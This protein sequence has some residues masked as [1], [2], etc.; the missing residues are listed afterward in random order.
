[1]AP[2]TVAADAAPSTA[3]VVAAPSTAAD[4]AA[5]TT[6]PAADRQLSPSRSGSPSSSPTC[7]GQRMVALRPMITISLA[8]GA[9]ALHSL[10]RL[11]PCLQIRRLPRKSL[12]RAQ[13]RVFGLVLHLHLPYSPFMFVRLFPPTSSDQRERRGQACLTT[14]PYTIFPIFPFHLPYCISISSRMSFLTYCR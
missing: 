5:L 6:A 3:A 8:A 4:D 2:F 10:D 11:D 7:L 12:A 1:M 14:I 9:N 13:A